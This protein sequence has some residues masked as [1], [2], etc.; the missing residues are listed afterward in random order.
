M[1]IVQNLTQPIGE[2][3]VFSMDNFCNSPRLDIRL[4]SSDLMGI[5]QSG[6]DG[7]LLGECSPS[8]LNQ[9]KNFSCTSTSLS[10][11]CTEIW[12]CFS[13][14]CE[15]PREDS[16]TTPITPTVPSSASLSQTA[17]PPS[18][19][20]APDIQSKIGS[21]N[22][23]SS[24]KTSIILG[25]VLGVVSL[26]LAVATALLIW[27]QRRKAHKIRDVD[28]PPVEEFNQAP[29]SGAIQPFP[30][31]ATQTSHSSAFS[32]KTPG[33]VLAAPWTGTTSP[34]VR[35]ELREAVREAVREAIPSQ[36][37]SGDS[38]HTAHIDTLPPS[39]SRG[40]SAD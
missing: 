21:D 3:S 24:Q 13:G 36:S 2:A 27:S 15:A 40:E 35:E 32:P 11:N 19:T 20:S 39:Y 6:G 26:C 1:M 4:A 28:N 8:E 9:P 16:V 18:N 23:S 25:A 14:I 31:I 5:F 33:P 17:V 7:T 22:I 12:T 34:R 29:V 38:W 10:L 30:L 37:R